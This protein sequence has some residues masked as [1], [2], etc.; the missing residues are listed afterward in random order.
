[1]ENPFQKNL[2]LSACHLSSQS[3]AQIPFLT[4]ISFYSFKKTMKKFRSRLLSY[5]SIFTFLMLNSS[6]SFC[7]KDSSKF[8]IGKKVQSKILKSGNMRLRENDSIP[9]ALYALSIKA[10]GTTPTEKSKNYLLANLNKFGLDSEFDKTL[11]LE[12]SKTVSGGTIVRYNQLYKGIKVDKNNIVVKLNG[13]DEISMVLNNYIQIKD[14]ID[15]NPK[16]S[17]KEALEIAKNHLEINQIDAYLIEQVIHFDDKKAIL[18]YKIIVKSVKLL[19]EWEFFI[20]A[21]NG[22]ILSCHDISCNVNGTGKVFMPDPL[23]NPSTNTAHT[24]GTGGFINNGDANSNDLRDARQDVTLLD[25]TEISGVYTLKGP[26]AE[27]WDHEP[28]YSGLFTQNS[29]DFSCERN[30]DKFEAVMAY[31]Y[32]DNSMRYLNSTLG[33]T[34]V[35]P[36]MN[37]N[38]VRFDPHGM[39][40]QDNS[41]YTF[42]D[43]SISLGGE[44][45]HGE[46]ADVILH[47]LGHGIHHWITNL[48]LSNDDGLSEGIGDYWAQSYSWSVGQTTHEL[49]NWEGSGFGGDHRYTNYTQIYPHPF[50]G[51]KHVVCQIWSTAI[52]G[53]NI[54][55]G[56]TKTDKLLWE[57]IMQTNEN[58]MQPQAAEILYQTAVDNNFT[59]EELCII[60]KHLN[61]KYGHLYYYSLPKTSFTQMNPVLIQQLGC[62][63]LEL[64]MH[65][66]CP[67]NSQ[68]YELSVVEQTVNNLTFAF[69]SVPSTNVTRNLDLSE[70]IALNLGN[71]SM[72]SFSDVSVGGSST[73]TFTP[74]KYYL[75]TI[76]NKGDGTQFISSTSYRYQTK[77]GVH[78]YIM[79]D[80]SGDNGFEPN[81]VLETNVFNSRHL[82]NNVPANTGQDPNAHQNPDHPSGTPPIP[83]DIRFNIV[84]K[85]CNGTTAAS[86]AHQIRLFWTR[87]R[88]DESWD[89]HWIFDPGNT[90]TSK[91]TGALV[92]AGSEI[93]I[94][95]PTSTNPYNATSV[96]KVLSNLTTYGQ[97]YLN[98]FGLSGTKVAWFPPDPIHYGAKNGY[99]SFF[100]NNP[101]ICLLAV[102]NNFT[103]ANDQLIWEP[104][105]GLPSYP[106][107]PIYNFVKNNNNVVTRNTSIVNDKR[108]KKDRSN[109]DWDYSFGT[110]WVNNDRGTVRNVR[111][112]IDLEATSLPTDFSDYGRIEVGVTNGIWAG[113]IGSGNTV[114]MN[115]LS[116]T[117]FEL[118]G[119]HGCLEN[120]PINSGA[121]EQIG[122]RFVFD[123]TATL[124][125]VEEHYNY[126][127]SATYGEDQGSSSVF[128]VTIPTTSPV[129]ESSKRESSNSEIK[130]LDLIIYPNP[131]KN[132]FIASSE[133]PEGTPYT[134]KL[135][136]LQGRILKQIDSKNK[137]EY[138]SHKFETQEYSAGVYYIS[139]ETANSKT[140]QR[141]IITE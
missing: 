82:W 123:G 117:L 44:I 24:Y 129:G 71:F 62:G 17:E 35:K 69:T 47:E 131:A 95:S 42:S 93:T 121:D 30:D 114:N 113:Y 101:T 85:G 74:N 97:T 51:A 50:I 49:S 125:S 40:N 59:D 43:Q 27:V 126:I 139:L 136:D 37:G 4:D 135:I 20:D 66:K 12:S 110:V 141:V 81:D 5:L 137:T 10:N 128:E 68:V 3:L 34:N 87:A 25:I 15:V 103:N 56:R 65:Q 132:L 31:Y 84:N 86:P 140:Q 55:L 67:Y 88:T 29:S 57:A 134:I 26:K 75:F 14:N 38:L 115:I 45:D 98:V 133:L 16:I 89:K 61:R 41:H 72:T 19:A 91:S 112:C 58:T 52:M 105:T 99:M 23:W 8:E 39:N 2:T 130:E 111:L 122:L 79:E 96:P 9:L 7:Q 109:G 53:I 70:L 83:N 76:V 22:K 64:T 119:T 21:I 1:M 73:I 54:E 104:L 46:D 118:V 107:I 100:D 116:P 63:G 78:S 90:V 80:Y 60:A 13:K 108:Y 94:Q 33:F 11:S 127:L 36:T 102:I 32:I 106:E 92:P 124:P 120:I 28:P 18:S 6:T 48:H 77:P 138:F